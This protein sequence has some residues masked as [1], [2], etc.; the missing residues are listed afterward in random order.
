VALQR[1]GQIFPEVAGDPVPFSSLFGAA[2]REDLRWY[3]EDYLIAPY[4]V[5]EQRGLAVEARLPSGARRCSK[6]CSA[7]QAR[8][9]C[10]RQIARGADRAGDHV[11]IAGF[12]E[13]SMGVAARSQRPTPLALELA[14]IDRTLVVEGAAAPVPPGEV[15]RVL[16]VIAGRR[17]S[18]MLVTR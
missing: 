7:P 3:L 15:L 9:R 4:A 17:V 13:P 6:A 8:A 5:Y 18:R 10:L 2:E 1:S 12:L 16:M 14:A 11:E